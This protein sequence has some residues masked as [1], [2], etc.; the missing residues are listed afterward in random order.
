MRAPAFHH[1]RIVRTL[2]VL[3]LSLGLSTTTGCAKRLRLTPAEFERIDKQEQ[4]VDDLRV[5]V[6]KKLIVIYEEAGDDEDYDVNKTITE[7]NE[8]NLLK[9]IIAKNTRGVIVDT[10][11]KNGAPLMW[12]T[13]TSSCKDKD[14]AYGFVQ[15]EDGVFRLA[16][17]PEREGYKPPRAYYINHPK[18]QMEPGKLKSLA[19]KNDVYLWKNKRGKVFSIDLIVKKRKVNK[20]DTKVIRDE[21]I[22]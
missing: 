5:F 13:F 14:C 19:E 7:S 17:M 16:V 15:A 10:D 4:A 12:V 18:R 20:T 1:Q 9:V 2:S 21:G 22:K 6:S 11:Q 3:A 8:D